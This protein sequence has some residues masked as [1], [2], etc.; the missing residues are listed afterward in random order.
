MEIYVNLLFVIS[1]SSVKH[2]AQIT[3]KNGL[4]IFVN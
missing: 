1:N 4:K 2:T 3:P